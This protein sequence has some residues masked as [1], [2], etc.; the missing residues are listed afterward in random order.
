VPDEIK[1]VGATWSGDM[2]GQAVLRAGWK[3]LLEICYIYVLS[4]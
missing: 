3:R 1:A 4:V 2:S